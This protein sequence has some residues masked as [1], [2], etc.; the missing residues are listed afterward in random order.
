MSLR[1]MTTNSPFSVRSGMS[2]AQQYLGVVVPLAVPIRVVFARRLP[3]TASA[4]S[5][6]QCMPAQV[7][8]PSHML[9]AP[10]VAIAGMDCMTAA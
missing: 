6:M 10:L 8:S 1:L 5:V 7:V 4:T 2:T 3:V 9:L